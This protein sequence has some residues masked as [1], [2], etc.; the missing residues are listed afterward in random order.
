MT[1][2]GLAAELENFLALPGVPDLLDPG[3]WTDAYELLENLKNAPSDE[4]TYARIRSFFEA[5]LASVRHG[6]SE[7]RHEEETLAGLIRKNQEVAERLEERLDS[8]Q[9]KGQQA[10]QS[11][12]IAR[13]L[14]ARQGATLLKRLDNESIENLVAKNLEAILASRTTVALTQAMQSLTLQAATL[15][16]N[17]QRQ[18]RQIKLLVD[19]MYARFDD[20]PGIAAPRPQL[21]PNLGDYSLALQALDEKTKAFCRSTINL[22]TDKN[23]LVKKFGL[24]IVLPLRGLF[25]QLRTE[26]EPWL[27]GTSVPLQ[28]HVHLQ[29]MQLENL[30]E[31]IA[32]IKDYLLTLEARSEEVKI[33]LARLL[34]QE[35]AIVGVMAR[36]SQA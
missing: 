36:L 31:D 15:F 3:R 13:K 29:K 22:I 35:A 33:A 1:Q 2:N 27:R 10:W 23:S 32:K 7:L 11:I 25:A 6:L 4:A 30:A 24:E 34:R 21:Q 12:N 9:Q 19:A 8:E 26:M 16:E 20:C 5:I 17:A 28:E 14:L 18:D